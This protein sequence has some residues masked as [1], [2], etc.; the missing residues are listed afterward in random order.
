M[1]EGKALKTQGN[2]LPVDLNLQERI[3]KD[4]EAAQQGVE[5]TNVERIRQSGKG[6]KLPGDDANKAVSSIKGVIVDFISSNMHYPEDYDEAN[7][8]PPDCFAQGRVPRDLVPDPSSTNQQAESC[9][10]CEHNKFGSGKGNAK[11]C[12]NT[13][14]LAIIAENADMDSHIWILTVPPGSI[15]FFDTFVSTVLKGRYALPPIGVVTEIYMD[16][17]K[18]FA[19]PRFKVD[20]VLTDEELQLYYARKAEATETLFQKPATTT[21]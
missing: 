11:S 19:A 16:P 13:R 6:F 4:L 9:K 18:D 7:P 12:K 20:R 8:S 14:Q 3:K 10:V 1:P 15:R 17:N 2:H 21:A 5:A